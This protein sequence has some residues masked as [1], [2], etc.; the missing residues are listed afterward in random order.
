ALRT[1]Q[2][3]AFET[4]VADVV[5]PIAGSYYVEALTRQIVQRATSLIAD[6]DREGGSVAAIESGW[7]QS[8]IADSAYQAQLAIEEGKQIVVGVNAFND[9]KDGAPVKLHRVDASLERN[10]VA[11]V[12]RYR[13]EREEDR[14]T[15]RLDDVRSA[16]QGTA[17]LMPTFVEALDAGATLGEISNVLRGVFGR[18]IAGEVVA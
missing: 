12:R 7:M 1:Q 13:A 4:G 16:A 17:N 14:V 15:A 18:Y 5:D 9:H 11:N 3:I 10:Q 2:I 8:R 6:V